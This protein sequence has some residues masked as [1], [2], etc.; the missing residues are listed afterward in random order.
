[1][2]YGVWCKVYICNGVRCTWYVVYGVCVCV[3]CMVC[4]YGVLCVC[5]WCCTHGPEGESQEADEQWGAVPARDTVD[6]HT[7]LTCGVGHHNYILA[8][9]IYQQVGRYRCLTGVK[10]MKKEFQVVLCD[11]NQ[12]PAL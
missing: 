1:M 2:V 8:L 4:V 5:V 7:S 6:Q 3:W 11:F 9:H 12:V 10:I